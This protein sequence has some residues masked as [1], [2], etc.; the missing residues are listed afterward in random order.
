MQALGYACEVSVVLDVAEQ[1][2]PEVIEPE[3]SDRDTGAHVFKLDDLV[4]E[5][6]ELF[7]AER[8]IGVFQ[9]E[10]VVMRFSTRSLWLMYSSR[11]MSGQKLT[12]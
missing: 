2:H 1:I 12:S 9:A 8:R 11:E 5:L 6:A 3:V 10:D 4:L 7:F